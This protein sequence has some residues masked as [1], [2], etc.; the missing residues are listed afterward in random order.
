MGPIID[1]EGNAV[2]SGEEKVKMF[3]MRD[4]KR[5]EGRLDEEKPE[6]SLHPY[7]QRN[8]TRVPNSSVTLFLPLQV[9]FIWFGF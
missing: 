1:N 7:W 8:Q 3:K 6:G 4:F 5:V 9:P 2:K